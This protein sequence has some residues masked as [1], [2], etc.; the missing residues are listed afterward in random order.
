MDFTNLMNFT[1]FQLVV[2]FL[3]QA[4]TQTGE[5][6]EGKIEAPSEDQAV[7]VLQ[8]K[9]FLILSL[10]EARKGL[11]S[12]NL[13]AALSKPSQKDVVMF[14]RQM[15]TLV[16][17]DVPLVEGLH[18]LIKQIEKES[19]RKVVLSL[20]AAIEGGSSLSAAL[21]GQEKVFSKFYISLVRAGEVAGK[22]QT[23]LTYLADYLERSSSLNSK[24]RG[25]LAYPA[26]VL[27]ALIVVTIIMMTTVLPQLLSIIKD[28]GVQ[29]IPVTTKI[30]MAATNFVNRFIVLILA[31]LIGGV[32][33]LFYY[34]K[35]PKGRRWLDGFIISIPEFGKV[36]TNLYLAR[37]AETLSTLIKSG[38]PILE[39]LN[40]TSDVV[41]NVIYKEILLQARENVR[42]GG[43][44]S[45]VLE[46]Y[47][48]FPPLVTSMLAIGE[49]TG[50]TDFMLENIFN[51]YK[52]EAEN[53]I[54]N[55]SQL[56]E[57]VLILVLGL[58]V[59]VLVAAVL[60][61]IYSLVGAG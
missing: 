15:A 19:F 22:L 36:V 37:I 1:N 41:G 27:F 35:T 32:I 53:D 33:Q 2:E 46:R 61:P 4:K 57:P 60:L 51:F 11:F 29:D 55:I 58:G 10:E 24:I 34:T 45:E 6:A 28:A 49:K 40:I 12:K 7:N 30:L 44:I 16:D 52:A 26:F 25:A 31:L 18:A 9:G 54:Q 21:G 13:G 17:A 50:R 14:T 42:G 47:K 5:L 8:Q 38:V 56:I 3:Y 48:E 39:G 20:S 23:T 59:G 43:T